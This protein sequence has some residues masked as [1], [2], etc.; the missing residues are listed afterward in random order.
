MKGFVS[1]VL[2]VKTGQRLQ[3]FGFFGST[4]EMVFM[5]FI[6]LSLSSGDLN[7]SFISIIVL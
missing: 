1:G 2:F 6:L 5:K 7:L 3:I 4:C